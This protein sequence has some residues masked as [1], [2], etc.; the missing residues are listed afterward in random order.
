MLKKTKGVI[1]FFVIILWIIAIPT[2]YSSESSMSED[3]WVTIREIVCE[4]NGDSNSEIVR[5][6][7]L[8]LYESQGKFLMEDDWQIWKLTVESGA[9]KYELHSEGNFGYMDIFITDITD[10]ELPSIILVFDNWFDLRVYIF[11]YSS[12]FD[13]FSKKEIISLS[14][15][16]EHSELLFDYRW[17]YQGIPPEEPGG[18]QI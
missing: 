10:N 18:G 1:L 3:H 11:T 15:G 7:A 6:S 8:G 12:S 14:K 2:I 13:D 5:L 4:L 16:K 17:I 9:K